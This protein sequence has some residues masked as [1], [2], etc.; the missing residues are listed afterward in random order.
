MKKTISVLMAA[1]MLAS[2][3]VAF[4]VNAEDGEETYSSKVLNCGEYVPAIDGVIDE[5]YYQSFRVVHE[6]KHGYN[7]EGKADCWANGKMEEIGMDAYFADNPC[8]ATSYFL[9]DDDGYFYVAIEVKDDDVTGITDEK[10][11]LALETGTNDEGLWLID[12]VQPKFCWPAENIDFSA[13]VDAAGHCGYVTLTPWVLWNRWSRNAKDEA[14]YNGHGQ[15]EE[16][17]LWAVQQTED[18][19]VV[20]MAFPVMTA[21]K[22]TILCEYDE[23]ADI[24]YIKYGLLVADTPE[25]FKYGLDQGKYADGIEVEGFQ[26]DDF[27]LMNDFG[28]YNEAK[29]EVKFTTETVQLSDPEP[30]PEPKPEFEIGDVN[31]D[32][33]LDTKDLIR[34]MKYIAAGA[35]EDC[36]VEAYEPDVTG[37]G[38]VNTV[39]LIRLMKMIAAADTDSPAVG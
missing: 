8:Q 19:Y 28:T 26:S 37:D 1:A 15:N 4:G 21:I 14:Q 36:G 7:D 11:E 3:T 29:I 34:L 24:G 31:M 33:S 20:E 32:G 12:S 17:N 23:A 9:W 5:A 25:G 39:D 30:D 27:I 13:R 2:S 22:D 6:F 10:Y 38:N 18:G 35:T 16:D